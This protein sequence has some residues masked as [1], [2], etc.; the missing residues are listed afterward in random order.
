[1]LQEV[2]PNSMELRPE[3]GGGYN[4]HLK[5]DPWPTE[6]EILDR[7]CGCLGCQAQLEHIYGPLPD[8]IPLATRKYLMWKVSNQRRS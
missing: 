7:N 4:W 5:T 1:M 3:H 8:G 2:D 6:E